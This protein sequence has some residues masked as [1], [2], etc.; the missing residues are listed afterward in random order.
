[1]LH[2]GRF[3]GNCSVF[4]ARKIIFAPNLALRHM[5]PLESLGINTPELGKASSSRMCRLS[6]A[7]SH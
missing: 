6:S 5:T 3:L 1:M 7:S 2:A 4:L